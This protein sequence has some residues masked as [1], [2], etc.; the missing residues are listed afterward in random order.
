MSCVHPSHW[1]RQVQH[2]HFCSLHLC[3]FLSVKHTPL[4]HRH[5]CHHSL[6]SFSFHSRWYCWFPM[7]QETLEQN[8]ITL[9]PIPDTGQPL[10]L[11]LLLLH[12]KVYCSCKKLYFHTKKQTNKQKHSV[13]TMIR[14]GQTSRCHLQMLHLK[15]KKLPFKML[16]WVLCRV[17]GPPKPDAETPEEVTCL[18]RQVI[19][20]KILTV[21][22]TLHTVM[23]Y[24]VRL[25]SILHSGFD[26]PLQHSDE[27]ER[28]WRPVS[29]QTEGQTADPGHPASHRGATEEPPHS[30]WSTS[31]TP[32][33]QQ[34]GFIVREIEWVQRFQ[35]C[36]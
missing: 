29:R 25:S 15:K 26:G 31:A 5:C 3:V 2:L 10:S 21:E 24:R 20:C 6:V 32:R 23:L 12:F 27:W 7:S 18:G 22:D 17:V 34:F 9:C 16:F 35:W 13:K 33:A 8:I 30:P 14:H 19:C 1:Q 4:L 11:V 36:D 28:L